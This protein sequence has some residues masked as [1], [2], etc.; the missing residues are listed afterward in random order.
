MTNIQAMMRELFG[1]SCLAYCYAYISHKCKLVGEPTPQLLTQEVLQGWYNKSIDDDGYVSYPVR[2][3]NEMQ[4]SKFDYIK[5]IVKVDIN[6]LN[7]L[8]AAGM[9]SVE[10]KLERADKKSHFAVCVRGK[11]IFDPSG[12]SNT[13]KYGVPVSYRKFV[14]CSSASGDWVVRN[15]E[16]L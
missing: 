15:K 4:T 9:Y 16:P 1:N 11:I 13:C 7:D 8:P 3:W 14:P 2:Y 6:S 5:D 12:D 10:F